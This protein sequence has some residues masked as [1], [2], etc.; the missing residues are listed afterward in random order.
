MFFFAY[1]CLIHFQ[2]KFPIHGLVAQVCANRAFS[3]LGH[4]NFFWNLKSIHHRREQVLYGLSWI[5]VE[6]SLYFPHE[7]DQAWIDLQDYIKQGIILLD[8][9]LV[10]RD[11]LQIS[12]LFRI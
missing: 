6:V 11:Q 4:S 9:G 12:S 8:L 2:L 7:I 10:K 5:Q 1:F 3:A